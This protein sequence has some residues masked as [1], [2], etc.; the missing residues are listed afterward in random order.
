MTSA[1]D[2]PV[3][4]VPVF[5]VTVDITLFVLIAGELHVLLIE[6]GG[7]PFKGSWALP[8]GFKKPTES[9][10][11]AATRELAEETGVT[12]AALRQFRSFGDPHR[13]PRGNVVTVGYYS[14]AA[15][16]PEISASTDAAG[17]AFWPVRDVLTQDSFLA[18]DHAAILRDAVQ[19]LRRE[20]E[21]SDIVRFFLPQEFPIRSLQSVYEAVWDCELDPSNFRRALNYK[22]PEWLKPAGTQSIPSNRGGRPAQLY[23]F[24]GDWS[25]G[26]PTRSVMT[27]VQKRS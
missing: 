7:D 10:D 15:N 27:S 24:T 20:I 5:A 22:E 17:A 18:F 1:A 4:Q 26:G 16:V 2:Q 21:V 19:H 9:L 23:R 14:V 11:E 25:Q 13:D 6:R 8:G 12:S 3:P